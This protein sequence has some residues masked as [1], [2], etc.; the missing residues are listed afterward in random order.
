MRISVPAFGLISGVNTALGLF[1][2]LVT[3][4][5][6]LIFGLPK[7]SITFLVIFTVGA[8][9]LSEWLFW[10]HCKRRM[11][12]EPK[13]QHWRSVVN[14]S[15]FSHPNVAI[16]VILIL[17]DGLIDVTLIKIALTTSLPPIWVFLSILGCQFLASPIQGYLSDFL[18]Q[19]KCLLF[20]NIMALLAVLAVF[21]IS[22]EEGAKEPLSNAI[23]TLLGL[24]S[25]DPT[26]QMLFILCGKGLFANLTVMARSAIA[27]VIKI[28][29]V[30]KFGRV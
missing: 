9:L 14:Q 12:A 18:S 24:S 15:L 11:D 23:L 4:S 8:K 5:M 10:N 28:E 22:L 13:L 26:T 20:A 2:H 21:G 19:K 1:L 17:M 27:K 30:K 3:L 29:T 6:I 16:S 25:L 7:C